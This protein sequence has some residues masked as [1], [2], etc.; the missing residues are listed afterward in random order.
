MAE[1]KKVP[2]TRKPESPGKPEPKVRKTKAVL[3]KT[4]A[5]PNNILKAETEHPTPEIKQ[6]EVHHH[7]RLEHK[8]KPWKEYLLEGMMIFVAV[9]MGF[10]AENVREHIANGEREKQYVASMMEDLKDDKIKL[11]V[12]IKTVQQGKI[13]L[14]SMIH[15]LNDP[16]LVDKRRSE[17][18]YFA[19]LGPRQLSMTMNMRTYEQ[20]KN[21]GN[22]RLISRMATSNAIMAYYEKAPFMHLIEDLYVEEFTNYKKFAASVFEPSIFIR[23]E[24]EKGD[25]VKSLDNPPLQKNAGAFIKQLTI[26][27]I[28]MNGS[29]KQIIAN[30]EDLL[31][32]ANELLSH[33]QK[34]Y[35]LEDE[36]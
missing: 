34:E 35:H 21:S 18:Y 29:R 1:R 12:H 13:L 25:I 2:V 7:P 20:L 30:D 19:R 11:A 22:F 10:I 36:R 23:Q 14:D 4:A 17:L 15:I 6:M 9:F 8:P 31:K 28:Y 33:L 5:A 27:A 16:A 26:Y 24:T 3:K 32:S